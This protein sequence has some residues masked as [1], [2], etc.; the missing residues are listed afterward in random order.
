MSGGVVQ[1]AD[2]ESKRTRLDEEVSQSQGLE[3]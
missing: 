2:R 3:N 1:N